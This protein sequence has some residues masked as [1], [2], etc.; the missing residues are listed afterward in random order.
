MPS[1]R[2]FC[3]SDG[4]AVMFIDGRGRKHLKTL[5]AGHR[6]T[7]RG[8]VIVNDNVIGRAEGCTAGHGEAESFLVFRPLYA[9]LATAIERPAEPVFAK[10]AAVILIRAGIMSGTRVI[11]A[12]VGGGTLT[13]A[14]L[15]AVGPEGAVSSYEIR[16]D[17]AAAARHNVHAYFGES[18]NWTLRV[19]DASAGF[20]ERDVDAVVADVP[21]P[22]ILVDAVAESL[23]PGGVFA[24]YVPTVLQIKQI[25]DALEGR[26]EFACAETVEIFE[27]GWHVAG[28]SV[29]PEQ[30]MIGH[31]G[32][33]TF[34]RRTAVP[35]ARAPAL[36]AR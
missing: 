16:D 36:G 25:H 12:G 28:R 20:E 3:F 33:L 23:R 19:R 30:R 9:E 34:I 32:F 31:T 29:R 2:S 10:D 5:R 21:D 17:L 26:P 18:E 7:I 1:P 24:V 11:E 35:F 27:R 13:M 6:I 22:D 15:A 4:D 8:T 14:L